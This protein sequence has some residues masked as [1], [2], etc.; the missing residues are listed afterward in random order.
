MSPRAVMEEA[1]AMIILSKSPAE[2]VM[3]RNIPRP[4]L[5]PGPMPNASMKPNATA[6]IITMRATPE[7]T[8]KVSRKSVMMRPS[9]IPE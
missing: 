4:T 3:I 8:M 7:G 5:L 2:Y 1:P 6:A 9:R